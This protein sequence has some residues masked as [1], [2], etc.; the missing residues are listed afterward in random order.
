MA[1][2]TGRNGTTLAAVQAAFERQRHMERWVV[3]KVYK[4]V[5]RILANLPDICYY[6]KYSE[7]LVDILQK[8]STIMCVNILWKLSKVYH[9]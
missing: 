3:Y 7:R 9:I 6:I 2:D 8:C 4:S 5:G 1:W